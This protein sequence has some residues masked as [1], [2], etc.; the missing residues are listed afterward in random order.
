MHRPRVAVFLGTR[1]EAIKLVPIVRALR[2]AGDVEV[3]VVNTGQHREMLDPIVRS[4]ELEPDH[5]L[6][7]MLAGQSLGDLTARLLTACDGVLQTIAPRLALIQGDTT[8]AFAAAL[9]CFYR[10]VLVGHVEAGLRTH[11]RDAPFPEEMNRALI[12]RLCELHFAPTA[13][14]RQNLL[15][16]GIAEAQIEVTGNTVIDALLAEV[17]RQNQPEVRASVAASLQGSLGGSTRPFLLVTGHRREN[18][19][20]PLRELCTALST[21]AARFGDHDIV[22]PVH[23]NPNVR[24]TV[25]AALA[26]APNVKLIEPLPYPEFVAL[27]RDC[28]LVLTDSGGIQ[29]EAPSLGKPVLV[30]RSATERPEGIEAGTVRLVEPDAAAIVRDVSELL[31]D[32]AAYDRMALASNPYGDGRASERIVLRLRRELATMP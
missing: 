25:H 4:L 8:T 6:K 24:G 19:G 16:E 11:R 17:A 21:L 3:V 31:T 29:E 5:D 13:R 18:F 23:M 15:A 27:L 28:R 12:S 1:P 22:Y 10:R 7:V 30:M 14:A 20:R 26:G 2:S 9:A 32:P